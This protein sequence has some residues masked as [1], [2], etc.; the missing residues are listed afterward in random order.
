MLKLRD[1]TLWKK[2][3]LMIFYLFQFLFS[4]LNYFEFYFQFITN[5]IIDHIWIFDHFD[6]LDFY[7]F[8]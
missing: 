7:L 8:L 5:M 3:F 1:A 4:I 2:I 6:E